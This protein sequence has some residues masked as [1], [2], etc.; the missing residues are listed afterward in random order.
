MLPT[1]PYEDV[2]KKL[3]KASGTLSLAI[4]R[5]AQACGE[6]AYCFEAGGSAAQV[7]INSAKRELL[8]LVSYDQKYYQAKI[9]LRRVRNQCPELVP[10][11]T[12]PFE[13]MSRVLCSINY[14]YM[15]KGTTDFCGSRNASTTPET[16]LQ[17][18]S[19]WRRVAMKSPQ[20]WT[21]IDLTSSERCR[22]RVLERARLFAAQAGWSQL[23]IHI[24]AGSDIHHLE[25]IGHEL[26]DF[27]AALSTRIQSLELTCSTAIGAIKY[28]F[29]SLLPVA[30]IPGTVTR[31][32]ISTGAIPPDLLFFAPANQRRSTEISPSRGVKLP[33]ITQ[34]QLEAF[35]RPI[36]RLRLDC[37]YPYW[38][39]EAYSGLVELRLTGRQ[40]SNHGAIISD[41]Q[42]ANVLQASPSLQFF[43]YGLEIRREKTLYT[44]DSVKLDKL[45]VLRLEKL[46]PDSQASVLLMI[47]PGVKDL[48]VAIKLRDNLTSEASHHNALSHFLSRS[49]GVRLYLEGVGLNFEP[50]ELLRK[51][52]SLDVL[53]LQDFILGAQYI[54]QPDAR[55]YS[56][57]RALYAIRCRFTWGG[58]Q[59]LIEFHSVQKLVSYRSMVIS[60]EICDS[61]TY[62]EEEMKYIC[63]LV[64][65]PDDDG[66]SLT[67]DW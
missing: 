9:P 66:H 16:Y 36:N 30:V 67:D 50:F 41:H 2:I 5:Y 25:T 12:L 15:S 40:R 59:N 61:D 52:T 35:L 11:H 18:C 33:T 6:L 20:L 65:F 7:L 42:L 34:N 39:S 38:T 53:V 29:E 58:F 54:N 60:D 57:I 49:P 62:Y 23:G 46:H 8:K 26:V 13:I 28:L 44:P 1:E 48:Q 56:Q 21:H 4:D 10:I 45:E 31:L 14:C 43:H 22:V 64:E 51:S 3:N 32:C 24:S 27:C 37:I 47:T 19:W 63:P 17:V 55:N